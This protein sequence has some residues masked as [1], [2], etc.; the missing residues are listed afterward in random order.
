[1][2]A[3]ELRGLGADDVRQLRAGVSFSGVLE[4][5]Y[6]ACLWSRL[7]ARVLLVLRT[8]P[9]ADADA[10]Y[11][12]VQRVDWG[13][14][15]GVDG[16]LA[17][18]FTG[19]STTIRDTQFG[20]VRVKDA[21][22]DQF[23]S[24]HAGRRPSV[25]AR[26]PDVRVNAHLAR[27]RVT[28]SL[29][30]SGDSLHRRGYRVD[31]VQVEAPLKENLAAAVLLFAAWPQEAAA[32]GS[33]LDPLCGSGTLPIEAAWI[34]ADVAPGLL[35]AEGGARDERRSRGASAGTAQR[36]APPRSFGLTRWKGHDDA[37]WGTLLEEARERRDA[38]LSRLKAAAPGVVVRS[39]D[40]DARAIEIACSCAVRAGVADVVS[41][42]VA[43]LDHASPPAPHGLVAANAPYGARMGERDEA[44][45]VCRQLGRR[46]RAAFGG[47]RA[48]VLAGDQHQS[49]QVGLPLVRETV[50]RNGALDCTL[51]LFDVDAPAPERTAR[52]AARSSLFA[53][54][55]TES[56]ADQ[57]ANRLRKNLR[58]IG[59][60]MRRR[61]VGCYRLY[62]ADLPEYN[63]AVDVYEGWLHVQEYAPPP[64][65][66]PDRA[67]AHLAEAVD[68]LA[69]VVDVRPDRIVVKQ[70]RRMRGAAQYQRHAPGGATLP[71]TEDGLTY[72]VDLESYLDTGL[73]L[74]QRETR[75]LIRRLAGGRRFLNLFAYTSTATVCAIAGGAPSTT[76]VDLSATYLQWSRRNLAENG[77]TD[78]VLE[79]AH[80]MGRGRDAGQR[81][82]S[83]RP[84]GVAH[85]LVQADCL[86]WIGETEAQYDLIYLDP[87]SFS[88]SKRMGGAT[89]DVQRDH[90][91]LIR[92]TVRRLLAP[93]GILLFSSN[94]RVFKLDP[95]S[96]PALTLKD[97]SRATLAPDFARRANAHHVWRIEAH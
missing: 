61:D 52:E 49:S 97:L 67:A 15:L 93:H 36:T 80:D 42:E 35:R 25:D 5:A 60:T 51:A 56:A 16:T 19:T 26:A 38:G 95:A 43:D 75:R 94:R 89:F 87:P 69:D 65:I 53:A 9:A 81:P 39:S 82:A 10:L 11:E 50:L 68:V 66:D 88:N 40:H 3:G 72:L 63:L 31:K 78:V 86:R 24:A 54:P 2:L 22:V 76:S 32:G 85:R 91:D 28:V 41:L 73:F 62:D 57:L 92:L 29:D 83:S 13:D 34:A 21:I 45:A 14:H 70:R 12:T 17:V 64:E 8:G 18:D 77:V 7:A 23:R 46:L 33:F 44:E 6:R 90:P 71:V 55:R 1:M 58:H 48:A 27:G 47:W 96:F 30:L 74:D 37:L 20:G 79:L 4:T 84:A 59:R